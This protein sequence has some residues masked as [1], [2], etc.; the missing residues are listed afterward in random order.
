MIQSSAY[1]KS[2]ILMR[3]KTR[4]VAKKV[5]NANMAALTTTVRVPSLISAA[6]MFDMCSPLW[7]CSCSR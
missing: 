3:Q 1:N 4:A 2:S 7:T 6:L 5:A